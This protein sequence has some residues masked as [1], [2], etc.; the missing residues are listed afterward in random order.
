MR[1]VARAQTHIVWADSAEKHEAIPKDSCRHTTH[2]IIVDICV[3]E[4]IDSHLE[5]TQSEKDEGMEAGKVDNGPTLPESGLRQ[6]RGSWK[7]DECVMNSGSQHR[8]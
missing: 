3:L 4:E 2:V 6:R 8:I 1:A 7:I 5:K